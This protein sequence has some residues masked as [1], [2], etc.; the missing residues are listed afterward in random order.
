MES[1]RLNL[2]NAR[3]L[4]EA[5]GIQLSVMEHAPGLP[6]YGI[7]VTLG[8]GM[9]ELAV[10]GAAQPGSTPR[11]TRMGSFHVDVNPRQ[12]LL[13]L[14]NHDVPGVIGRVGTALGDAR[15]NIAEYH[16]ARLAQGGEALAAISVDG[17]VSEATRRA[18]LALPDVTSATVVHFRA[19]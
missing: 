12:T 2:I 11:L 15:V 19:S 16:Q 1:G 3:A 8:G 7:D 4:A 17:E 9:T 6:P 5:R 14:T 10:A 13:I 18:M